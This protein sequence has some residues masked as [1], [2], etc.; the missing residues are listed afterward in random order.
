MHILR[1]QQYQVVSENAL[2]VREDETRQVA[3]GTQ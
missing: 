3:M 2:Q 1:Q